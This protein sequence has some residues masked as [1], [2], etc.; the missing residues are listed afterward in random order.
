MWQYVAQPRLSRAGQLTVLTVRP[1]GRNF[2]LPATTG[3][4]PTPLMSSAELPNVVKTLS[5]LVPRGP[6]TTSHSVAERPE[7]TMLAKSA[8]VG[9][10]ALHWFVNHDTRHRS[11]NWRACDG[12]FF[13]YTN[14]KELRRSGH[15]DG[16]VG[17]LTC[18]GR[19]SSSGCVLHIGS[20][21]RDVVFWG[22][23]EMRAGCLI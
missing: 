10:K 1:S 17:T 16:A 20:A 8:A 15:G 14:T 11:G 22:S 4:D 18:S 19:H 2:A 9:Q 7:A 13:N 3:D 21:N 5:R 6:A 12:A 23:R